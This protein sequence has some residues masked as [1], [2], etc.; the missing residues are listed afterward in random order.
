MADAHDMKPHEDAG[1]GAVT[2]NDPPVVGIEG[3]PYLVFQPAVDL[4]TG[5]LLG[6]ETLLR[7]SDDSGGSIAPNELIPWA[8][9][10][11]QMSALSAWIL[12]EACAQ[13]VRWPLSLQITANCSTFQ[14]QRGETA[15]AALSA[16]ETSG[17]N[18]DRLTVEITEKSIADRD[19]SIHIETMARLGIQ[20]TLDDI[21]AEWSVL[22]NLPK[23]VVNTVKIDKS[24]TSGVASPD[25][26]QRVAVEAIVRLSRSLGLCTVAEAVET[27]E[28]VATLRA[29]GID[30]AQG[31]FFSS[32]MS[33]EEACAFA[34]GE[35]PPTF[36]LTTPR[37]V[38]AGETMHR[39]TILAEDSTDPVELATSASPVYKKTRSRRK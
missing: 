7:W 1:P 13:A 3:H 24:L 11:G 20:I 33:A 23:S 31:Y 22:E 14:L 38:R 8:E 32:P 27:V 2:L 6:F 12:S 26:A 4:T 29:L 37:E 28:Q 19:A 39:K 25:G 9:A 34:S 10:T 21:G 16:L 35:A 15:I 30:V 18:P 5:R 36:D 17:L